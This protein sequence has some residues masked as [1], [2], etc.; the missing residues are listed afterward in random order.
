MKKKIALIVIGVL[1]AMMLLPLT[2][3]AITNTEA[4]A[5]MGVIITGIV[6]T[7]GDAIT[8]VTTESIDGI[9]QVG[10]DTYCAV[11]VTVFCP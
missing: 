4:I 5:T 9:I 8:N 10:K 7:S 11:G 3:G 6:D 2:V 1:I